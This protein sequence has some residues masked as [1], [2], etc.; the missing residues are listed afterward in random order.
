VST[1]LGNHAAEAT[2]APRSRRIISHALR[3]VRLRCPHC[4]NAVLWRSLLRMLEHCPACGLHTQRRER[5]Y[6]LGAIMINLVAA[7]LLLAG[8][9]LVV[10]IATWPDPP[11][12]LLEYG[13][14]LLMLVAPFALYPFTKSLWL[15]L[16]L[17]LRPPVASEFAERS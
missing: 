6:F 4:G 9:L 1:P 17:A 2:L 15:A 13:G 12:T 11:W 7:E 16:D 10:V 14:V 3:A 8:A 5:D